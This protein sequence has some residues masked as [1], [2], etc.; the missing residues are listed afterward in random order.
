M[1][2]SAPLKN[3]IK[4]LHIPVVFILILTCISREQI[5][6]LIEK[7]YFS[8]NNRNLQQTVSFRFLEEKKDWHMQN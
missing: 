6:N 2:R 5:Y 1:V 3:N 8:L 4:L 7:S